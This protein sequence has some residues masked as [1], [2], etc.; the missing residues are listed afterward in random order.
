MDAV[1]VKVMSDDEVVARAL[2][3]Q[4]RD[5]RDD[6]FKISYLPWRDARSRSEAAEQRLKSVEVRAT[7]GPGRASAGTMDCLDAQMRLDRRVAALRVV[8]AIRLYAASHD[9][10]LPEQSEQVTEVPVPD[11]P[12]TGKPLEYR[13]DGDRRCALPAG[14]RDE[15]EADRLPIGSRSGSEP[16]RRSR[17]NSRPILAFLPEDGC[18]MLPPVGYDAKGIIYV[19]FPTGYPA[20]GGDRNTRGVRAPWVEASCNDRRWFSTVTGSR[21]TWRPWHGRWCLLWNEAAFV[22]DPDDFQLYTWADWAKLTPREDEL[23]IRTVKFR[24]RVPEVLTLTRHDRPRHNAVTFSRRNLFKRDHTTCQYCG[25]RPGTEELTIDHV[26]PALPGGPDH[27]GELRPGLRG[28]QRPESQPDSRAGQHEAPAHSRSP[29]LE[30][31]LRRLHRPHRILVAI[32]QRRLLERAAGALGLTP[33]RSSRLEPPGISG[34]AARRQ[35]RVR[36]AFTGRFLAAAESALRGAMSIFRRSFD[37]Q[38]DDASLNLD[39][40]QDD[41]FSNQYAFTLLT[42]EDQH[43]APPLRWGGNGRRD[44]TKLRG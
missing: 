34:R 26:D 42:C 11:D 18:R 10:K 39:D 31:A 6:H 15:G 33:S 5:M 24:L 27:L 12:A 38:A 1:R 19:D 4:Y 8:E 29:C 16:T 40:G 7:G 36:L 9:G 14:S 44:R 35:T 28:V 13:R 43:D 30:A 25:A 41:G 2:V 37:A 22:V 21:C 32:P 3:G 20:S 23:F 17:E